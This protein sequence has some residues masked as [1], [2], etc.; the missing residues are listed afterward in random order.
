MPARVLSQPEFDAIRQAV[1]RALPNHLDEAGFTRLYQQAMDGALAEAESTAGPAENSHVGAAISTFAKD[2]NPWPLVKAMAD[3]VAMIA[4]QPSPFVPPGSAEERPV[5]GFLKGLVQAH[6]QTAAKGIEPGRSVPER[7]AYGTAAL[8]PGVGPMVARTGEAIGEGR[9]G[10]A[11][12]HLGAIAAPIAAAKVLG[13]RTV[14]GPSV[15]QNK[16][17]QEAAAVQFGLEHDVPV[18]LSTATGN[19]FIRAQQKV[20]EHTT[21]PGAV[22]AEVGEAAEADA[23]RRVSG[24]LAGRVNAP[25]RGG[26]GRPYTPE[27]ASTRVTKT[28][29]GKIKAADQLADQEYG[30]V[31]AFEEDPNYQTRVQTAPEGSATYERILSRMKS[32]VPEGMGA[33]SRR[34]L[35]VMRQIEAELDMHR[36][37]RGKLVRDSIE[38]S[39]EHYARGTSNA[40]V[41][42]DIQQAIGSDSL[43][44]VDMLNGLRTFFDTGD[45]NDAARGAFAV[46]RS[47]LA[48]GTT[49]GPSLPAETPLLGRTERIGLATDLTAFRKAFQPIYQ[50]LLRERELVPM[51]GEQGRVLVALDR[52]MEGP[53]TAPLSI[54]DA[55]LGR[56]KAAARGD[57]LPELRTQ[58]QGT[59]AAAVQALDAQVRKAA[60]DAGP[61]VWRALETGRTATKAKYVVADILDRLKTE[62]VKAFQQ[63][64]AKA[65]TGIKLLEQIKQVAPNELPNVGR[66]VLEQIIDRATAEGGWGRS[67]RA[68]RDFTDLGPRT[69]EMLFGAENIQ[70]L[71]QFF[72]LSKML[73]RNPNPSGS[74]YTH[75]SAV[76]TGSVISN[77]L[78]AAAYQVGAGSLAM[79]MRNP[80]FVK[81][82]VTG[83]KIPTAAKATHVA[84][85]AEVANIAESLGVEWPRAAQAQP[86]TPRDDS[87]SRMRP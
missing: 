40:A 25:A 82:F 31:R 14:R 62:P 36:F 70:P 46:A 47:R 4:G 51:M 57:S 34:D 15:L 56:L 54:V 27:Q 74:A 3:G 80:R 7:I 19:R 21:L 28:G 77:P 79:L 1:L 75:A 33:P 37:S 35:Q 53:A 43:T 26:T 84:A 13:G 60:T 18:D 78:W 49:T 16:N 76:A 2:L 9:Y 71:T 68:W 59:A 10:E 17:P 58:G 73:K 32:G 48:K 72:Q 12:G 11:A 65:D 64:T 8:M 44:G 61:E 87:Q 5:I 83:A 55:A 66:A 69:K 22:S 85:M 23:L 52:L 6:V 38:T 67:D 50:R 29:T 86:S 20:A 39:G 30:K 41:Y 63:L 81:A 45:W 42:H 24:E